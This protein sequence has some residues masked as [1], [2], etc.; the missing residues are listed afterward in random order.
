MEGIYPSDAGLN[1]DIGYFEIRADQIKRDVPLGAEVEIT[2]QLDESRVLSGFVYIPILD[3][4]FPLDCEGTLVKPIPR[5][6]KLEEDVARQTQRIKQLKEKAQEIEDPAA[7]R[8]IGKLDNPAPLAAINQL[9]AGARDADAAYTCQNRLLDLKKQLAEIERAI[10]GPALKLKARQEIEWCNEV[11]EAHGTPEDRNLWSALKAELIAA[12]EGSPEDL[13]RRIEGASHLRGRL[14]AGQ[15]WWWLG[16]Y[17]Y[18]G[19]R[20]PEMADQNAANKWFPHVERSISNGDFEALKSGCRQLWALLPME[21][22]QRGYGGTT[23]LAEDHTFRSSS[24]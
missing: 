2:L 5:A 11:V 23:I 21:E 6:S 20:R 7:R 18:L 12:M 19:T 17:K 8:E 9:L 1:R 10:E 13:R 4:E 3:E 22:Q 16:V 24:A 15:M 14:S